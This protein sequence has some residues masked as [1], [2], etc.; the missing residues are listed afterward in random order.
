MPFV[1]LLLGGTAIRLDGDG[2]KQ[3]QNSIHAYRQRTDSKRRGVARL[4]GRGIRPEVLLGYGG[5]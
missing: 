4:L 3:D 2:R 1:Q 5:N